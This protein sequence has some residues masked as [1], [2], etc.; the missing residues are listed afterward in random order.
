MISCCMVHKKIS[1]CSNFQPVIYRTLKC[2]ASSSMHSAASFSRVHLL[3]KSIQV[4][5]CARLWAH[6]MCELRMENC[7]DVQR[8]LNGTVWSRNRHFRFFKAR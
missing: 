3:Y 5:V 4:I 1:L 7:P 2:F 6:L 8:A